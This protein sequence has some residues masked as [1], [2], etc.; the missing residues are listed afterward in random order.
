MGLF[1]QL[2]ILVRVFFGGLGGGGPVGEG[3]D[4]DGDAG[5]HFTFSIEMLGVVQLEH[6]RIFWHLE[7]LELPGPVQSEHFRVVHLGPFGFLKR[8]VAG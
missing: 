2:G 3:P 6:L 8:L 7:G 5:R 1:G 4:P